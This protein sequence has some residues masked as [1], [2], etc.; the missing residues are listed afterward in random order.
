MSTN[1]V[2]KGTDRKTYILENAPRRLLEDA[3]RRAKQED[4]P[5]SLK[6]VI[7]DLLK[8]WTYQ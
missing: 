8:G 6:Q 1:R 2:V 4:P 3:S 7:L 5:R